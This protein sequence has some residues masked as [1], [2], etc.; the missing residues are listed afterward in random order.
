MELSGLLMLV[1]LVLS[2]VL[3][4]VAAR[5]LGLRLSLVSKD[6][7]P[8]FIGM[9][10]R[11]R[12]AHPIPTKSKHPAQEVIRSLRSGGRTDDAVSISTAVVVRRE[13]AREH[14][15]DGRVKLILSKRAARGG[16][17]ERR[18]RCGVRRVNREC[19][20]TVV[21][22][23]ND[24]MSMGLLLHSCRGGSVVDCRRHGNERH[25]VSIKDG[26]FA[27]PIPVIEVSS[28]RNSYRKVLW[29]GTRTE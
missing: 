7:H 6:I 12:R 23:T 16:S 27:V 22:N 13:V 29:S 8:G 26:P 28:W 5:R 20:R 1:L 14:G 25:G 3:L 17:I 18:E 15:P 9:R 19:E 21:T 10:R 2:L 11:T 24:L 4:T